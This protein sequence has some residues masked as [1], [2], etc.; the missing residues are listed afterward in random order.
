M[1]PKLHEAD[2]FVLQMSLNHMDSLF[3]ISFNFIISQ[4][5]FC[6]ITKGA[7][8]IVHPSCRHQNGPAYQ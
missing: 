3:L 4:N 1:L 7:D 5:T 6:R 2:E 8:E